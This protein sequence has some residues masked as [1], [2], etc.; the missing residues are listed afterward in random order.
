MYFCVLMKWMDNPLLE[1]DD[2]DLLVRGQL[3]LA[4][5]AIH[6]NTGHSI[7]CKQIKAATIE[8]YVYAAATFL[9]HF[10]GID[11]RKD[12]P[13]NNHMGHILGPVYKDLRRYESFPNRREPYSIAM[14][15]CARTIAA[16]C[17]SRVLIPALV[18]LF[19]QGLCAGYR[20]S[21]C[22]QPS[23]H[24]SIGSQQTSPLC[25]GTLV[26]RAIVPADIRIQTRGLGRSQGLSIVD[27]SLDSITHIWVKWRLQKNGSHGEEKMFVPNSTTCGV[28]MVSSLYRSLTRFRQLQAIDGR[29]REDDTPLSVYFHPS[30]ATVRLITS[31]DMESFM[32]KLA[33]EVYQLH[34]VKD[35]TDLQRWGTH[36]LRV[37][38]CV[39]L[40]AMGFSP[41]DIQ[42]I[43]RWK[44][45]AFVAYLRNIAMLSDRQNR[46]FNKAQGMP[47]LLC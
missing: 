22:A 26:T 27:H 47:H 35:A 36:S 7:Y 37:G 43:L 45:M 30:T 24:Y 18:D 33:S 39:I 44:S 41:L 21:E 20:L 14:H 2:E 13:A 10:T 12:S 29:L 46:A 3:Q 6:L 32:R 11:Y 1:G 8:Q 4:M 5:Y 15:T 25:D 42:F 31:R 34:P 38:A 9:S 23:G 28:C 40:H 19:E 17:P 16:K